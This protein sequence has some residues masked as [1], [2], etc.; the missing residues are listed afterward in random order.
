L[1]YVFRSLL[2]VEAVGQRTF[3]QD[4]VYRAL[5]LN[6]ALARQ[7][8]CVN[9]DEIERMVNRRARPLVKPT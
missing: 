2:A 1:N 9:A 4:V 7:S 6:I 5:D 3:R 8:G